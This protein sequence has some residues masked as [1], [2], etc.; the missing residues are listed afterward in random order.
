M[1]QH[2]KFQ[3]LSYFD[4]HPDKEQL[5]LA[6]NSTIVLE[7]VLESEYLSLTQVSKKASKYKEDREKNKNLTHY[8]QS[9][10]D[11]IFRHFK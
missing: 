4:L 5:F 2:F 7:T 8:H 11:N 6:E 1:L 9:G 3:S 10:E